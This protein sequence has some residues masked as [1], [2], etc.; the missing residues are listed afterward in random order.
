MFTDTNQ[1]NMCTVLS[2][3]IT[4]EL[5]QHFK[6]AQLIENCSTEYK[7]TSSC[8][9]TGTLSFSRYS[10]MA[11]WPPEDAQCSG[12]RLFCKARWAL[13]LR[14]CIYICLFIYLSICLFVY[15]SVCLYIYLFVCISICLFVYLS[16]CLYI[17]L[18]ACLPTCLPACLPCVCL[19]VCLSVCLS[20][21]NIKTYS[22][23]IQKC[24][25]ISQPLLP[26]FYVFH[27]HVNFFRGTSYLVA[28]WRQ[29]STWF[30]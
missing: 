26:L 5:L 28:Y 18:S 27:S 29:K 30:H 11:V 12:I 14:P 10:T 7:L 21:P 20:Y 22:R 6:I 13:S 24:I 15:L 23:Q 2:P 9:L 19:P 4:N 25:S 16:V 8:S 1:Q 3:A 17:Y